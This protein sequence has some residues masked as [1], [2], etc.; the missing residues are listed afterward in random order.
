MNTEIKEF[1]RRRFPI[2]NNWSQGNCYFLALI[3]KDRFNGEI[4]YDVIQ[5]H[6]ITKIDGV[7]YDYDG[8]YSEEESPYFIKWDEFE[9]YDCEQYKRVIRDC[10]K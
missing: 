3:L 7:F 10:T 6:F 1:I 5:G 9:S 4:Y 2:D 8:I